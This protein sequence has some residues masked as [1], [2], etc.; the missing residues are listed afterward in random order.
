MLKMNTLDKQLNG[1]IEKSV[2]NSINIKI[3]I[4]N[5]TNEENIL[6]K[7]MYKQIEIEQQIKSLRISIEKLR[8]DISVIKHHHEYNC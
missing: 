1:I 5:T 2:L 8:T 4:E 3:P 7:I 6:N